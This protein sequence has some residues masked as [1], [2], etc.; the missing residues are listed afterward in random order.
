MVAVQQMVCQN[1]GLPK[2]RGS[3]ASVRGAYQPNQ[4]RGSLQWVVVSELFLEVD[5]ASSRCI[6][7]GIASVVPN[8]T[9]MGDFVEMDKT[10]QPKNNLKKVYVVC[11]DIRWLGH[12]QGP[13]AAAQLALDSKSDDAL[14]GSYFYVDERGF[15]DRDE[16]PQ[17]TVPV[18]KLFAEAGPDSYRDLDDDPSGGAGVPL[19]PV[20]PSD[21]NS[22]Q[23]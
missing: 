3:Q 9:Q 22:A 2:R 20:G 17:W 11:G 13:Q 19:V 14:V 7:Q 18:E 6:I 15:R 12:A 10:T 21:G 1:A 5:K 8:V 23:D 16:E 4:Q